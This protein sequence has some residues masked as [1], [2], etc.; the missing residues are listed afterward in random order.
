MTKIIVNHRSKLTIGKWIW[1]FI[2]IMTYFSSKHTGNCTRLSNDTLSSKNIE[3][4]SLS[5]NTIMDSVNNT[6]SSDPIKYPLVT[7]VY[8]SFASISFIISI[9]LL[10]VILD[11]LR[12]VSLAKE[13]ILL[14]LYKDVVMIWI[15]INCIW[16]LMVI[17]CFLTKIG[18]DNNIFVATTISFLLCTLCVL[19]YVYMIGISALNFYMIKTKMLDPPMPWGDDDLLGIKVIRLASVFLSTGVMSIIYGLGCYPK[20]HYLLVKGYYSES[21]VLP[22]TTIIIPSFN[23]FLIIIYLLITIGAKFYCPSDRSLIETRIPQQMKYFLWMVLML[24]A[25]FHL[26]ET[27][28]ILGPTNQWRVYEMFVSLLLVGTPVIIIL[29]A[30]QL[31]VFTVEKFKDISHELFL[32][33]I[34][35]T[36]AFLML[37]INITL[38]ILY[39]LLGI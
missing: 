24:C 7:K 26:V 34:Y 39:K 13:C 6:T 10:V 23:T 8:L 12:S 11:Y 16:M 28:Q 33:S 22:N 31:K 20:I 15:A 32:L 30:S 37:F 1:M 5:N 14:H 18:I 29:A 2:L 36:P 21:L 17:L 4:K 19:L 25:F 3:F 38:Y 9:I 27:F 35:L